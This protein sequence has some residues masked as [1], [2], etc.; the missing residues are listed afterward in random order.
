MSSEQL[1]A[2]L[3]S[4]DCSHGTASPVPEGITPHP[5]PPALAATDLCWS[6]GAWPGRP[7]HKQ[8]PVA[9]ASLG[10]AVFTVCIAA[11]GIGVLVC[12]CG[13]LSRELSGGDAILPPS[14]WTSVSTASPPTSAGC[15]FHNARAREPVGLPMV[16]FL[17]FCGER[18]QEPFQGLPSPSE[19]LRR[20]PVGNI[21]S[22]VIG[23]W[24]RA[25]LA[26][27]PVGTRLGAAGR[28]WT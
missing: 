1:G 15:C 5:L 21:S 20:V 24:H 13:A 26:S 14:P 17:P 23:T 25:A 6:L 8:I 11:P 12:D 27:W 9:L 3:H 28:S 18:C 4:Q 7:S 16:V 10:P 19:P 22:L 2:F